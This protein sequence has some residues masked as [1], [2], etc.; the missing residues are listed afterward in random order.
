MES[1]PK[2]GLGLDER[3]YNAYHDLVQRKS[4]FT[5]KIRPFSL[6]H[7]NILI[8]T[9]PSADRSSANCA[10]AMSDRFCP[11]ASRYLRRMELIIVNEDLNRPRETYSFDL[12]Y[13]ED[14]N[15]SAIVFSGTRVTTV[16]NSK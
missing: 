4:A 1:H 3:V 8:V 15:D 9:V 7:R 16:E 5:P 14:E 12:D 11:S 6:Q 10:I 13:P 2:I